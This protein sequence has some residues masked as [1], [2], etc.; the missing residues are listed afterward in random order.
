MIKIGLDYEVESWLLNA[1]SMVPVYDAVK[2]EKKWN[3]KR[4]NFEQRVRQGYVTST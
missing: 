4:F 1:I 2:C 3:C